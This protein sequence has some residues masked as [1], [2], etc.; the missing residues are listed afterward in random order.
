MARTLAVAV[1]LALSLLVFLSA[2]PCADARPMSARPAYDAAAEGT[3]MDVP[4]GG[5]GVQTGQQPKWGFYPG[6]KNGK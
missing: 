2:C 5:G 6:N 4:P 1:V 3:E